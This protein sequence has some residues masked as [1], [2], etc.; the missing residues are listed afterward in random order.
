MHRYSR[1]VKCHPHSAILQ[2]CRNNPKAQGKTITKFRT[3]LEKVHLDIVHGDCVSLGG[4]KYALLLVDTATRY[5]W[6]FGLKTLTGASIISALED[7]RSE[8]GSL[9]TRF[10]TDFDKKLIGG[11]VL[12]WLREH[13]TPIISAPAR[14]QSSNGVV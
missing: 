12:R 5:T 11:K 4:F 10:H 2:Q 3:Y 7:F 14:Q 13:N 6:M 9:P 1:G 8:A